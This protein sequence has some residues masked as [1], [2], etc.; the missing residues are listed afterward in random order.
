M[1]RWIQ[2]K[3][4][5]FRCSANCSDIFLYLSRPDP[6]GAAPTRG[7]FG[8]NL[9]ATEAAQVAEDPPRLGDTDTGLIC[10]VGGPE[11]FAVEKLRF[12]P[13]LNAHRREVARL[14]AAE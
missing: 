7:T 5:R 12:N 3:I 13:L 14:T 1:A 4:Y 10:D 6:A 11:R 9:C 2:V 8:V